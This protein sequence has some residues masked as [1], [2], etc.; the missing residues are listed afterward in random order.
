M[1]SRLWLLPDLQD[2]F[3]QARQHWGGWRSLERWPGHWR[4]VRGWSVSGEEGGAD[5]QWNT[6]SLDLR[7]VILEQ[8]GVVSAPPLTG[9]WPPLSLETEVIRN[10]GHRHLQTLPQLTWTLVARLS[11]LQQRRTQSGASLRCW[12]LSRRLTVSQLLDSP[13]WK[14]S[15]LLSQLNSLHCIV[16]VLVEIKLTARGFLA[17]TISCYL[18]IT[19]SVVSAARITHFVVII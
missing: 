2:R 19:R 9:A 12:R 14:Q 6:A 4:M 15:R 13:V 3:I 8:V 10:L 1:I 16:R 5:L 11:P 17:L 18:T 7:R